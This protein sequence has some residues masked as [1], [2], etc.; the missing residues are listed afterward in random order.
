MKPGLW[1][2]W[3]L[4]KAQAHWKPEPSP[5]SGLAGPG[6]GLWLGARPD[7]SL[8]L[9]ITIL[10][11]HQKI[12]CGRCTAVAC[13]CE[14]SPHVWA[15]IRSRITSKLTL[16]RFGLRRSRFRMPWTHMFATSTL[17]FC[18]C[19]DCLYKY[20]FLSLTPS[21]LARY[22]VPM[23]RFCVLCTGSFHH[24]QTCTFRLLLTHCFQLTRF[25]QWNPTPPSL[26][27]KRSRRMV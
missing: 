3:T 2:F 14:N 18:M 8:H 10:D 25:R 5:A 17:L 24:H 9:P 12:G 11:S 6:S 27:S 21:S 4:S 7:T 20:V 16:L 15:T 1:A 22:L 23:W 13:C 19:R 26:Q